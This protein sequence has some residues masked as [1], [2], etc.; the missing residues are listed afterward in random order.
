MG[1]AKQASVKTKRKHPYLFLGEMSRILKFFERITPFIT[2]LLAIGLLY[3]MY[4]YGSGALSVRTARA[5]LKLYTFGLMWIALTSSWNLIGGYT[6][7]I[8]FGHTLFVGLGSYAVA[9]MMWSASYEELAMNYNMDFWQ[10]LPVAFMVGAIFAGLAGWPTL[11]LKGPYFAIAMLGLFVAVREMSNTIPELTRGGQ[12]ISFNRPFADPMDVFYTML[13]LAGGIF[14]ISLWI[15]RTQYGK[16]LQAIREDEVGADMRGINTTGIKIGIFMLAGGCTAMV[17]A[18]RAWWQGFIDPS[19]VYIEDYT[20]QI[21]MMTMLGGMGRPWGPVIGAGIFYYAQTTIWA[22]LGDLN[23]V[24]MGSFLIILVLFV[25]GGILGMV[26]PEDRGLAWHIRR[27]RLRL[28]GRAEPAEEHEVQGWSALS[29]A[30]TWQLLLPNLVGVVITILAVVFIPNTFG[31]FQRD[32]LFGFSLGDL[33]VG[34]FF[35]Y[36]VY[37]TLSTLEMVVGFIPQGAVDFVKQ[38]VVQLIG[39]LVAYVVFVALIIN[40]YWYYETTLELII[41]DFF[42]GM[43]L[44]KLVFAVFI[45]YLIWRLVADLITVTLGTDIQATIDE[46]FATIPENFQPIVPFVVGFFISIYAFWNQSDALAKMVPNFFFSLSAGET[47]GLAVILYFVY[48]MV[49]IYQNVDTLLPDAISQRTTRYDFDAILGLSVAPILFLIAAYTLWHWNS[50]IVQIMPDFVFGLSGGETFLILLM[51]YIFW[52]SSWTFF[53]LT[54]YN[55]ELKAF[56]RKVLRGAQTGGDA[57][58]KS[59]F[60]ILEVII[61]LVIDTDMPTE[62]APGEVLLEGRGVTKDF[63]GLRAV[64]G[65][66]FNVKAGEIVGL[67]G[68]NGSGKTTMFNCISGV[69][70]ISD[71]AVY[72][73]DQLISGKAP[74]QVN[75]RGLA[76]TFQKIRVYS[77]L[78]VY[79]NMIL[80]RKWAGVPIFLWLWIAPPPVRR[81]ADEL[82]EF[83]LLERVR[84]NLARNLSGGQQRLLEIGM[85]LMSNPYIVLLDEATSGVNPALIEEIKST[86]KRLNEEQG[87]TFL[88]IEHNMNFIMDLCSRLY[89]LDYGTKIA[90]GT[91][92]EIQNNQQV[93]EAYFGHD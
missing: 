9:N 40:I 43:S 75:R 61:N 18:T 89:V 87:V 84:D 69:L 64:N 86:I 3:Y 51:A 14:F 63:G 39:N 31:R 46:W 80:A 29:K 16:M 26:D 56:L 81:R 2:P 83:L 45:L 20:I 38:P 59:I 50:F 60:T 36:F 27:L 4:D 33:A 28:E 85:S 78:P 8:D 37:Q 7:Y 76:R 17:G 22:E 92:L 1:K 47:A 65:V 6:G 23:L 77:N 68:P 35:L 72:L 49:R 30:S 48:R 32:F 70:P 25:P 58:T 93:I 57:F 41:P 90:E 91:P 11:R 55:D 67:L 24:I 66:D 10:S 74:W 34:A 73:A 21:I 42:L 5:D 13:A 82:L 19:T 15:Y 54:K 44:G 53:G 52:I 62:V 12:G 71:G 79:E 88:L